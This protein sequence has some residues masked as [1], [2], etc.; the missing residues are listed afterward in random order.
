MRKPL[1]MISSI[2]ALML[3]ITMVAMPTVANAASYNYNSSKSKGFNFSSMLTMATQRYQSVNTYKKYLN[4]MDKFTDG[5]DTNLSVDE[6]KIQIIDKAN[7]LQKKYN[8]SSSSSASSIPN[9][10]NQIINSTINSKAS[11][12][13]DLKSVLKSLLK[14]LLGNTG[15]SIQSLTPDVKIDNMVATTA[16]QRCGEDYKVKLVGKIYYA[17]VDRNGNPTSNKWVY[18]VHGSQMNGQAMADAVGQ[19]YLDQGY[20]ILAPDSRGYGTSEGSVAM[21]Y[22]ESLDVWDWL[23]YLNS[24]Y[25]DKCKQVIIHGVSLGGAT[26]VFASGL[27]VNGKTLKDQ[28]VIGL[29]EDCGYTSLTGIIKG[30]LSSSKSSNSADEQSK[31][32]SST[33]LSAKILGISGKDNLSS[34]KGNLVDTVIKKLLISKIGVG[35]TESNFDQYQNALDSLNRCNLPILI[36]HGTKDSMVPFDNSTEI[37]NTAMANSKIPY[38]Q[39]FTA[40]G[41]QHAFIILGN[42][43][44]VYKGHVEHFVSTAEDI[45]SGKK[46]NKTSDY[47]EET[48][49]KTSVIT[50][51]IKVLKLIKNIIN[52]G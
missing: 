25:G 47:K 4:E 8:N 28:N 51:L 46:V 35:L 30:M 37:Y 41:E 39:R 20:N 23:T 17:N 44:N 21:G 43:Y 15:L 9:I 7:E 18:L 22:V 19:M 3:I 32:N 1:K 13:I 26:T 6:S 2:V 24:T 42:K 31:S 48:E 38:V 29:V 11:S 45:A 40:E 49:Q 36:I 34:L 16:G 27:E 10:T 33:E 50:Q 5:L 52:K 14:K 12:T